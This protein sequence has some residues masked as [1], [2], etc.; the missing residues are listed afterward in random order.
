MKIVL[1]CYFLTAIVVVARIAQSAFVQPFSDGKELSFTTRI[2]SSAV[3]SGKTERFSVM[4]EGRKL[5][6]TLPRFSG[7]GYG[8]LISVSGKVNTSVLDDKRVVSSMYFPII[9]KISN[10]TGVIFWVAG[11]IRSRVDVVF[12][13]ALPHDQAKLLMGIV[14]GINPGFDKSDQ[15][16]FVK[17]GVMHVIAASGM[18]VTLLA[19]FLMPLFGRVMRRQFALAFTI[20]AIGGYAV[21]SG[22]SA[23]I[24]RAAI[25]SS[26]GFVGMMLGRQK[27][28]F[29]AMYL[30]GCIMILIT[31]SV[32][33]DIGF[34]LSFAATLGILLLKP[35]FPEPK[36][37]KGILFDDFTTTF[38]AQITTMPIL[39]YYFHT[40]GVLS[41]L[42][43]VLVLWIVPP[44]MIIGSMAAIIGLV[45]SWL[46]I[47][48]AVLAMPFLLY[49]FTIIRFFGSLSPVVT[50]S[51]LPLSL[52]IGYY[53]LIFFLTL[54]ML[55]LKAY[56]KKNSVAMGVS[57]E[58]A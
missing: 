34:Q 19:G 16:A 47:L 41:L 35:L 24:V 23:S 45:S 28:A 5:S 43:N 15:D 11:W 4:A 44:V 25:M 26:V 50:I 53:F 6:L 30:T 18:N 55:R 7:Y 17:T 21:L 31:P 2:L 1:I 27:T 58:S 40:L 39:L 46:G 33:F 36:R 38:S 14:F 32:I 49:F 29:V 51:T 8:D 42:V 22:L 12:S 57:S 48:I 52:V 10:D 56:P 9:K 54:L 37:L 20:L 3:I 13:H